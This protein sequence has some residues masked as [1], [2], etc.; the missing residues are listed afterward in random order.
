M[1]SLRLQFRLRTALLTLSLFSLALGAHYWWNESRGWRSAF[2]AITSNRWLTREDRLMYLSALW[3]NDSHLNRQLGLAGFLDDQSSFDD[4]LL[5]MSWRS[6]YIGEDGASRYVFVSEAP[7]RCNHRL[8]VMTD[9]SFRVIDR[10]RT[11]CG[12]IL[13]SATIDEGQTPQLTIVADTQG[14]H[15]QRGISRNLSL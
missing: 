1:R 6:S 2:Y 10:I 7:W 9:G 4:R 13:G 5:S 3:H 14:L 8:F 15:F 12:G 11:H